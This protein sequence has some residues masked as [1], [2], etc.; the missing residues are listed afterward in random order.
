M[1]WYTLQD[2]IYV[3]CAPLLPPRFLLPPTSFN[4]ERR[5]PVP[6]LRGHRPWITTAKRLQPYLPG[7][8]IASVGN[9]VIDLLRPKPVPVRPLGSFFASNANL[10]RPISTVFKLPDELILSILSHVSP[11]PHLSGDYARFHMPYTTV[12]CNYYDERA[13]FIRPLSMTCRAMRLRLLPW[14][15]GRLEVPSRL[16]TGPVKPT[17][18]ELNTILNGPHTDKFLASSVKYFCPLPCSWIGTDFISFDK[19]SQ[20]RSGPTFIISL[21]V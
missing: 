13:R 1:Q 18:Q 6:P 4:R 3:R 14:V 19:G 15:W 8:P 21:N 17:V 9:G 2:I 5:D 16:D 10:F 11:D 7:S 12:L 20:G